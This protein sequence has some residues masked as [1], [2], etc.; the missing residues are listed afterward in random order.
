MNGG[1]PSPLWDEDFFPVADFDS[2]AEAEEYALVVLAMGLPCLILESA[3][4]FESRFEIQAPQLH[5]GAI[6]EE[7]AAYASEGWDGTPEKLDLPVFDPSLGIALLWAAIL[8]AVFRFQ[9]QYPW[10]SERFRSSTLDL[11]DRGEWWRP[12]T[13]MFLHADF[14]HLLGNVVFGL[15]F[16]LPVAWS[17]GPW[18]GWF[19]ILFSGTLANILTAWLRYP[20]SS[21]SLGASTATFAALGILV[22][23]GALV[24]VR[25]R[26]YRKLG[27]IIVPFGAGIFLLG[28]LGSGAPPTDVLGHLFA[29]LTG[30]VAGLVA[31][32][33]RLSERA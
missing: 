18:I 5:A 30:S 19:L 33:F 1:T 2:R 13:A 25:T 28:W 9:S 20:A 21:F 17:V 6:R 11:F 15:V 16:F 29:F 14:P 26:S 12:F 8:F 23:F 22:G 32:A 31:A 24:V 27:G 7:F 10:V 3:S 4:G